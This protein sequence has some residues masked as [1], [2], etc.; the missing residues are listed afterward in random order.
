MPRAPD[1]KASLILRLRDRSDAVAWEEFAAIYEPAIY[2][3]ARRQGL[4]DADAR[5][6]VQEVLLSVARAISQWE[7]SPRA[8]FRMWL[9]RIVRGKL[10]DHLRRR[11]HQPAGSG[12][13]SVAQ[14]LAQQADPRGSLSAEI[15]REYRRELFR[16]AARRV[17]RDVQPLTWEAF[18]RTSVD[19]L[20]VA[21]AAE[22]LGLSIGAVY[23]ARSRVLARLR[24]LVQ[25]FQK[26]HQSDEGGHAL[27]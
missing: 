22:Q 2:R 1:T 19:A 10:I 21:E 7:P 17:R 11:R 18:W 6:T 16:W 8:Q 15:D 25:A 24:T 9:F 23:I 27:R 4:Q 13:S 12:R 20:P 26:E 3:L 14:Q 5:E